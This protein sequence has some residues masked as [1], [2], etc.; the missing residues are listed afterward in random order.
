MVCCLLDAS[1][2]YLVST[3]SSYAVCLP[4]AILRE[5][6]SSAKGLT[7]ITT[8]ADLLVWVPGSV[9]S[10]R[11]STV[12]T[13]SFVDFA[14]H[15]GTLVRISSPRFHQCIMNYQFSISLET[16]Y[17]IVHRQVRFNTNI[18]KTEISHLK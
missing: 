8:S 18:A 11:V 5:I 3:N 14:L 9:D 13:F 4:V 17:D 10:I 1:S 7:P 6:C 15:F 12:D 16:L 2:T